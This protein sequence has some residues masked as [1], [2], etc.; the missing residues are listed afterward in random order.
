MTQKQHDQKDAGPNECP[1]ENTGQELNY[2]R[3][4]DK[5]LTAVTV[6]IHQDDLLEQVCW[7]VVDHA[8]DGAQD[9]RQGLVHKDEDHRDLRKVLWVRQLLTSVK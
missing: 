4:A 8:V 5:A 6:V 9:H 1:A 2:K 3:R 7:R